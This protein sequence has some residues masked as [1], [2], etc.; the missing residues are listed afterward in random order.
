MNRSGEARAQAVTE[1]DVNRTRDREEF[2]ARHLGAGT[3]A[4]LERDS[5][6]F[7]HQSLST[8]CLNVLASARGSVLTDVAGRKILDFHGN[9]VHQVGHAHP[10]VV[11]AVTRQLGEL[12]FCPRRFTNEPAVACA[13]RLG[14][15]TG[16]RLTKVLLAPGGSLAMGMAM[17]LARLA[18]GKHKTLSMWGA[19]HGAG[20]DTI[21]IG[22]ES[23]FRE[24]LGPLL[25]GCEHVMPCRPSRCAS[26]CSGG[27]LF[28]AGAVE[29]VLE[30]EPDIGAVIAEP[31]RCTTV[32]VPHAEYWKR[33]RAAC[34]RRGVLLIF[35]EIPTGLGRTGK[36]FAYEHFGVEPDILVLGKGLGGG[37]FPQAAVLARPELDV[38]G[39][40][41]L[42]HYTHEKSPLG[43][44]AALA[45]LDVLREEG[46]VERSWSRGNRWRRELEER[47]GPT[48]LVGEIRGLGM[49]IGI[50]MRSPTGS[51]RESAAMASRVLYAC[52]ESGLS[53]KVSD[54]R[55]LTLVPPL[56]VTEEELHRATGILAGAFAMAV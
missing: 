47:L 33:V 17:K 14:E 37:L 5:A 36:M 23:V 13:E 1:G 8:P 49:L 21:S 28:C 20:L 26:A 52:M 48:G 45:T 24:H 51:E 18:T 54:G 38:A 25:P 19:F 50:E 12:A 16:G 43:A 30:Q 31:V 9:S 4:I 15:L 22:G 53:L 55:V 10:R 29:A 40:T 7:L 41:A 35:D 32:D 44:A 3:R 2:L 56:N 39:F 46:L 34:D 42:G 11:E 6:S 27:G